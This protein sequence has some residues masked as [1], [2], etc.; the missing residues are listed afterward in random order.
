MAVP[1]LR[2]VEHIGITVPDLDEADA[3][4]VDVL[5]CER[6]YR[7]GPFAH[8]QDGDDWMRTH[9]AVHPRTVMRRL[10]FYRLGHGANLEVIEYDVADP[11]V[12]PD[13]PPRNSDPGGHHLALYVDD[14]DVAVAHL[15]AHGV[16]FLDGP[17][18]SGGASA[19]QRWIY[20]STPWGLQLE[21]VSF[22]RGKAYEAATDRR[23]WHPGHLAD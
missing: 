3:F 19:G 17:T 4:L 8:P 12:A 14:L 15:R 23:L 21:L 22:P 10:G 16:H 1:G 6:F 7:V 13:G 18:A 11:G 2:G 20:C 5:G 9:L